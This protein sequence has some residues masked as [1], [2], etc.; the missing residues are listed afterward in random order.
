MWLVMDPLFRTFPAL[1]YQAL[2]TCQG[3]DWEHQ[4]VGMDTPPRIILG[5]CLKETI[6]WRMANYI[7]FAHL[8]R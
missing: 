5:D 8:P 4:E 7:D 3:R 1:F 2:D 6:T